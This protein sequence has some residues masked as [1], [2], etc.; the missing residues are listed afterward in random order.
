VLFDA[1][2]KATGV[3]YLKGARLYQ[4]HPA[5][6]G[7]S[8]EL[9]EVRARREVILAGGAFNTPQLL[10][11]SGVG[12]ADE[13]ARH[14]IPLVQD[15][16]GVGSNLQDRYEVGVVN[17]M[18]F[19]PWEVL[20]GAVYGE[21]DSQFADWKAG[22]GVYGTNGAILGVIQRS[23]PERPLPDLFC[24]AVL[25]SFKGYFPDYSID[26]AKKLNYLTWAVLKA[27]TNNTGGTVRL[28]SADP[29]VRPLIDF[30]YFDEGNDA[31]GEDLQSVVE[32]V[33]FVRRLAAP[34]IAQG[35]IAEEEIPGRDVRTDE[36]IARFVRDEAWGHHAS[37]TCPIG[38]DRDAMAVLDSR[39]RVRGVSGLRV[40]DAS[41]FPRIPGFFIVTSVYMIGEKAA[42]VIAAEAR[43]AR[44]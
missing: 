42:D 21:G 41:V 3:Q 15:L 13:L 16:P 36:E 18:S 37:C 9:R 40:V 27:H 8:R 19:D 32:G 38:G 29:T 28:A 44:P 31:S 12:P 6:R 5:P 34:L 10:M 7:Q 24:F 22:G 35:L 43:K 26:I 33:K 25:A 17:R 20:R 14:Q 2:R 4:A 39:F 23:L 11:L 30:R 1:Q